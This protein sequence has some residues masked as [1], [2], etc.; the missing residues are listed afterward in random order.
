[1]TEE[2]TAP[3]K[4][5]SELRALTDIQDPDKKAYMMRYIV[6]HLSTDDLMRLLCDGLRR[7]IGEEAVNATKLLEVFEGLLAGL[8]QE[9]TPFTKV[10]EHNCFIDRCPACGR[11]EDTTYDMF[12]RF[13]TGVY[14][15]EHSEPEFEVSD[16][17]KTWFTPNVVIR[18]CSCGHEALVEVPRSAEPKA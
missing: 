18:R 13:A 1:M 6:S 10:Q 5:L 4:M 8:Y 7:D 12:L 14:Y 17:G 3:N 11:A 15:D 16:D 2:S 9:K